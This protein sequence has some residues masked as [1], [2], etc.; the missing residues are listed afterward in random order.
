MR[1]EPGEGCFE[2]LAQL[3]RPNTAESNGNEKETLV[4]ERMARRAKLRGTLTEW[5]P[6]TTR[7][8]I[9]PEGPDCA[10]A[11]SEI[12]K[13]KGMK[14]NFNLTF[15]WPHAV[16]NQKVA[17]QL[18]QLPAEHLVF[19]CRETTQRAETLPKLSI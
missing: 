13:E 18:Q 9:R 1:T 12:F 14:T 2:N 11:T 15:I 7:G 17:T 16:R 6:V 5:G 4:Q 19:L 8:V 10:E 3:G